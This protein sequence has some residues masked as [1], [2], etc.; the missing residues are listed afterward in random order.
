[1]RRRC[2]TVLLSFLVLSANGSTHQ[3]PSSSTLARR[4]LPPSHRPP[5]PTR[6][7][8]FGPCL[9]ASGH[10]CFFSNSECADVSLCAAGCNV[11]PSNCTG[12]SFSGAIWTCSTVS[13]PGGGSETK[14]GRCYDTQQ[15]AASRGGCET[16]EA[17][18]SSSEGCAAAHRPSRYNAEPIYTWYCPANPA[19]PPAAVGWLRRALSGLSVAALIALSLSLFLFVA[20]AA[21]ACA[22]LWRRRARRRS[23]G[24]DAELYAELLRADVDNGLH[25]GEFLI[26]LH[27]GQESVATQYMLAPRSNAA[28]AAD[29]ASRA[30]QLF[31]V[32]DNTAAVAAAADDASQDDFAEVLLGDSAACL[33]DEA[34]APRL[35]TAT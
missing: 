24:T 18:S 28:A 31:T 8:A 7:P 15:H 22:C 34:A 25:D 10:L 20:L 5:P 26:R 4:S 33:E 27:G 32:T 13:S 23:Y 12:S 17:L 16:S 3:P 21:F 35:Q 29:D 30:G 2:W 1:M 9:S 11:S 14:D 19:L 6:L